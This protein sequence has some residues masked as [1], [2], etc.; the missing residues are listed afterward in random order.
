MTVWTA[1]SSGNRVPAIV[2]MTVSV[3]T[4]PDYR[5]VHLVLDDG[6]ELFASPG[7]PVADNR[8]LAS[9]MP[10][11]DLDGAKVLTIQHIPDKVLATYDILPAGDTGSYWANDIAM[12]STLK[13]LM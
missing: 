11:D 2:F 3:P 13:R 4:T 9:L 6:R 12:K 10:G 5:I 7:H 1:D 8:I